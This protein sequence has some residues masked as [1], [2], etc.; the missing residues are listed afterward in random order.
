MK[1]IINISIVL[2]IFFLSTVF[3]V[4]SG[5]CDQGLDIFKHAMKNP[6]DEMT[7]EYL[8]SALDV[9]KDKQTLYK[10]AANY[11][12]GWFEK[13]S[14]PDKQAK[15]KALAIKFYDK[16]LKYRHTENKELKKELSTL[17]GTREFN[18]IAFRALR[19]STKGAVNTGLDMY[20]N[21]KRDSYQITDGFSFIDELGDIMKNNTSI[22]ISL[23]G[24]TDTTGSLE[25]NNDLSLKRASSVKEYIMDKY[26]IESSRI[27]V[28]GYGY[29]YLLDKNNPAGSLN[30]RV[31]VI[32]LSN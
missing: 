22:Q 28:A 23:E 15:Y 21:F 29:K 11:Y 25:Y 17:K 19:P 31:E 1:R 13:E 14:N 6:P 2:L 3:P 10:D 12:K 20:I 26:H 5:S 16:A 18:K 30:R 24:H 9:C 4:I 7:L 27:Q 32:K 8:N